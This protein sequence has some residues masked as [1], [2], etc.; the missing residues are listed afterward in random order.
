MNAQIEPRHGS[1]TV[2]SAN[3]TLPLVRAIVTDIVGLYRDVSERK[4]RLQSLR[5]GRSEPSRQPDVYREEVEQAQSDLDKDV[6]RLQQFV[7]ELQELGIELKDPRVGLVD[8]PT[9]MDGEAAY[10][11]WKL[12]ESEVEFWH[13]PDS[14]LA[15]RQPLPPR[16]TDHAV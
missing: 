4:A 10:L 8:F 16:R 1:F 7:D 2:A 15:G 11:C 9:V 5:R 6:E 14:G 13:T 3:R 12:G